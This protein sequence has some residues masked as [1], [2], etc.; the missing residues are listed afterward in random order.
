MRAYDVFLNGKRLCLAGIGKDGY[1]SAYIT[2]I[3]EWDKTDIDVIGMVAP[4]KVYVRWTRRHLQTGDEIRIRIL[5]RRSVDKFKKI[6]RVD[7]P[8]KVIESQKRM[9]RRMAKGFGW[10]LREKRKAN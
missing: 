6:G 7:S 8:N 2:Y 5:D 9:L 10:E 3:S 1:V 4:K